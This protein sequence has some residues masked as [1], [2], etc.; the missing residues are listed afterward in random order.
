ME[1]HDESALEEKLQSIGYYLIQCRLEVERE[2]A[3]ARMAL[4]RV[5]RRA[6]I[7]FFTQMSVQLKAGVPLIQS[8]EVA[9]EETDN[10][11]FRLILEAIH[12]DV[13]AGSLFYEALE[14]Y[15]EAFPSHVVSLVRAGEMSGRLPE[16]FLDLRNY[17]EWLDKVINDVRQASIYPAIILGVVSTFV[18]ALFTFVI[19]KFMELMK[20]AKVQVPPLTQFIFSVSEFAKATWWIW[21]T[22]MIG[23]AIFIKFA[24]RISPLLAEIIDNIKLRIP[25]LGEIHRM[26]ALSRFAHNLAL[27][28]RAGIPIL[29]ALRLCASLVGNA[30]VEKAIRGVE[31]SVT[32][33][34]GIG[35]SM[36]RHKVFTSILRRMVIL[37]EVT[38]KLDETLELVSGY[39]N[40][41]V[42]RKIKRIFSFA[43]PAVMLFLVGI[44][45]MVALSIFM[46]LLGMMGGIR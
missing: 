34:E 25:G 40:E 45:G 5:K 23:L 6:L 9:I 42:P 19:P 41:M 30:V 10:L 39:Y 3:T 37:G 29:Q 28:Y 16:T 4:W 17:Y 38:G 18:L 43:E 12:R 44:V 20:V 24:P 15:P 26:I 8:I 46:P 33:G 1:A 32:A 11:R 31:N 2:A 22:S 13:Q 7:D 27:M 21:I 14:K 36:R 35:E